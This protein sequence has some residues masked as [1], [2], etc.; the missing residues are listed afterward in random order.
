MVVAIPATDLAPPL[1]G[2]Y[3]FEVLVLESLTMWNLST[4]FVATM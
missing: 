1:K 3:N 4:R 2:L